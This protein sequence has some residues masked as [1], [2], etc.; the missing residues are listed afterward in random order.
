ME[1][2]MLHRITLQSAISTLGIAAWKRAT[3]MAVG[4]RRL[5]LTANTQLYGGWGIAPSATRS[6]LKMVGAMVQTTQLTSLPR[7]SLMVVIAASTAAVDLFVGKTVLAIA[8]MKPWQTRRRLIRIQQ[9]DVCRRI[10][11]R[12]H[13]HNSGGAF[14]SAAVWDVL[15]SW[16]VLSAVA[17][18]S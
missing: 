18:R 13:F 1:S 7:A 14:R 15:T 17:A 12:S 9:D 2:V 4:R 10:R 6:T 3:E 11:Q 5:L 16:V 8:R